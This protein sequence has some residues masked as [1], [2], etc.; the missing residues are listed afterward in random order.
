[1][2]AVQAKAAP[3]PEQELHDAFEVGEIAYGPRV[4]LGK[5]LRRKMGDVPVGLL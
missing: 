2:A 5:N 1:M 3:G 4:K